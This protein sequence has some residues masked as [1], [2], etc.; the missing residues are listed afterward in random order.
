MSSIGFPELNLKE[1][2]IRHIKHFFRLVETR[3]PALAYDPKNHTHEEFFGIQMHLS[4]IM[5]YINEKFYEPPTKMWFIT[6]NERKHTF[7]FDFWSNLM[8]AYAS[9]LKADF[10]LK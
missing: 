8:A 7:I 2:V 3:T 10:I 4:I 6:H 9:V 1:D 5:E